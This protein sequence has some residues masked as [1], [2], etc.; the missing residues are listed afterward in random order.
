M[1]ELLHFDAAGTW[2]QTIPEYV[3]GR[4]GFGSCVTQEDLNGGHKGGELEFSASSRGQL[5]RIT[6]GG[7]LVRVINGCP[8]YGGIVTVKDDLIVKTN[9]VV[10]ELFR[11]GRVDSLTWTGKRLDQ[12]LVDLVS[13]YSPGPLLSTST[14]LINVASYVVAGAITP[15]KKDWFNLVDT[16][17]AFEG[18]EWGS[19]S[20][21]QGRTLSN[22]PQL[23]ARAPDMSTLHYSVD[24]SR[25]GSDPVISKD[26]ESFGNKVRVYYGAGSTAR[27][28][29]GSAASVAKYG[30]TPIWAPPI[31]ISG[32]ATVLADATQAAQTLFAGLKVEGVEQP[33]VSVE[34]TLTD[35][36]QLTGIQAMRDIWRIVPGQNLLLVGGR[37]T[38]RSLAAANQPYLIHAETV[39]K[40]QK[41]RAVTISGKRSYNP[42]VLLARLKARAA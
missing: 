5:R 30:G 16:F 12:V 1:E 31:D 27:D 19:V 20:P 40:D 9:G 34:I 8:V 32:V 33:A 11:R 25:L 28:E 3:G 39:K 10:A 2:Q 21:G 6:E 37:D 4:G 42:A 36:S 22:M 7:L 15:A 24:V 41:A 17:N 26:M 14:S 35:D 23:F 13:T 29:T 38:P 18:W